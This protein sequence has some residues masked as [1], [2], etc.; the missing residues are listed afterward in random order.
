MNKTNSWYRLPFSKYIQI[1][2]LEQTEDEL[3]NMIH[4]VSIINNIEVAEVEKLTAKEFSKYS[5]PLSFL[6]NEPEISE[7]KL[8]W[9]IKDLDKITMDEFIQFETLKNEN[10]G[11]AS[12]L[13]FMS[14]KPEEEILKMSTI[15]VLNGFFLLQKSLVKFINRSSISLVAKAMKQKVLNYLPW[16]KN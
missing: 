13:A 3:T 4:L 5:A 10:I 11:I 14:D 15:E 8:K 7:A 9:K 6:T 1:V 16:G 12:I 2:E